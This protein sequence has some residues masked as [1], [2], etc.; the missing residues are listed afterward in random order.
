MPRCQS[1]LHSWLPYAPPP[2]GGSISQASKYALFDASQNRILGNQEYIARG[3]RW[4]KRRESTHDSP[5]PHSNR[6]REG[7]RRKRKKKNVPRNRQKN[8]RPHPST[9]S[10]TWIASNQMRKPNLKRKRKNRTECLEVF[11]FGAGE[12]AEIRLIS[13]RRGSKAS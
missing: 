4:G 3:P 10:K 9:G 8:D 2:G 7:M 6:K 1:V 13:F 11:L 5:F 12:K